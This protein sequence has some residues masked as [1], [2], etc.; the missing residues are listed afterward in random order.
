MKNKTKFKRYELKY[1]ITKSQ[2]RAVMRAM[3]E[4]MTPDKYGNSTICNIYY[5]TPDQLLIRR[6][7]QSP[8]YKEKL[9]VRSYNLS[10]PDSLVYVE[11]K[12]KYDSVVYKRRVEMCEQD[13]MHYLKTGETPFN[14]SQIINEINY[15]LQ[16]YKT[17]IPT[18]FLSYERE[19]FFETIND[20]FRVTF[21]KNILW[22]NTDLSLCAGVYGERI[23]DEDMVLMEIKT[24]DAIPLWMTTILTENKI[25]KTKFSKYGLAYVRSFQMQKGA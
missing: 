15:F 6:S 12:K 20:D 11:L 8:I 22:R 24:S 10:T 3:S 25:Y 17:L 4:H 7:I 1:L 5:D 16:F 13:A 14:G 23:I 21:D 9:R 2:Q 19:A 18:V